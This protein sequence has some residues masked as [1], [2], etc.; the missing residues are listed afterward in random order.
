MLEEGRASPTDPGE[1]APD[2]ATEEAP[3]ETANEAAAETAVDAEKRPS[4]PV[5]SEY[6]HHVRMSNTIHGERPRAGAG[7]GRVSGGR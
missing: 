2:E 7:G 6:V 3:P 1:Q 4:N 5:K